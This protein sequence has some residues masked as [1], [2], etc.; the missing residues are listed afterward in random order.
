MFCDDKESITRVNKP[1]TKKTLPQ[2]ENL[3]ITRDLAKINRVNINL[4]I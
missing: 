3:T 4:T 1:P 2:K